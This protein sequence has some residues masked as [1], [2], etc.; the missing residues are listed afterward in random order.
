MAYFL[1]KL[2]RM[3]FSDEKRKQEYLPARRTLTTF[4]IITLL[5]LIVTITYA[6]ICTLNFNKGLKPHLRSASLRNR[7]KASQD[8]DKLYVQDGVPLANAGQARM[9]I[10]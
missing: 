1:F 8:F 4:A 2:V 3:Y 7:R 10:D 9:T 5:L 6:I